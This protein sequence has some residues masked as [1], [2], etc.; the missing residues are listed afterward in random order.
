MSTPAAILIG[1]AFIAAAVLLAN[2]WQVIV[3][4]PS[5]LVPTIYRVD[6][7]TGDTRVCMPDPDSMPGPDALFG[8]RFICR[9]K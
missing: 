7:L 3:A 6:R 2:R 9:A 5:G 8:A 4:P 1:S